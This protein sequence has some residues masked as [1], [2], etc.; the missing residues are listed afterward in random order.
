VKAIRLKLEENYS[1]HMSIIMPKSALNE[2]HHKPVE[3]HYTTMVPPMTCMSFTPQM[4][5]HHH[6]VTDELHTMIVLVMNNS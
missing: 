1:R 5:P 3:F 6:S 2:I 4:P